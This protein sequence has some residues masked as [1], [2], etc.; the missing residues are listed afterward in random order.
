MLAL[1]WWCVALPWHGV[2]I[3][4]RVLHMPL[5]LLL[6]RPCFRPGRAVMPLHRW[7]RDAGGRDLAQALI[8]GTGRG[9]RRDKGTCG[10]RRR[11]AVTSTRCE[12]LA[13]CASGLRRATAERRVT[14]KDAR[15]TQ[16]SEACK[17]TSDSLTPQ[18]HT[19]NHLALL[20]GSR[21]ARAA[22]SAGKCVWICAT[23]GTVRLPDLCVTR[24]LP[25]AGPLA[26]VVPLW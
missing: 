3:L 23:S 12:V 19:H 21:S 4:L 11:S 10:Q 9:R 25:A 7:R 18:T 1:P 2:R 5:L 6:R 14:C 26:H 13:T 17:R 22:A 24:S 16:T 8:A 20:Q 15:C